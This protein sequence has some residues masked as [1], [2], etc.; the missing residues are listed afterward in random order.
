[1]GAAGLRKDA[2]RAADREGAFM[3]RDCYGYLPCIQLCVCYDALG[4]HKTAEAYNRRAGGYKS[5][6]AY[7]HNLA[8]FAELAVYKVR[9]IIRVTCVFRKH[10][11]VIR[12]RT[13]LQ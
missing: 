3:N 7:Q 1:M 11:L 8:Y 4:D 5:T 9:D 10:H 6:A 12:Q 13:A 2:D